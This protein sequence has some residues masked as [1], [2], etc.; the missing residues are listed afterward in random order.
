MPEKPRSDVASRM[1]M[2]QLRALRNET[3]EIVRGNSMP[4]LNCN[5]NGAT[6]GVN[7]SQFKD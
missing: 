5:L 2:E 7:G 1:K 6:C 4:G 3:P